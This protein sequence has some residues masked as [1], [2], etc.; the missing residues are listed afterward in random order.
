MAYLFDRDQDPLCKALGTTWYLEESDAFH[1]DILFGFRYWHSGYSHP[2]DGD[3]ITRQREEA[4]NPCQAHPG[5][6]RS[7]TA[8]FRT[9]LID[10]GRHVFFLSDPH[11]TLGW[12]L[13]CCFSKPS[14]W[15]SSL[16]ASS[17]IAPCYL[18]FYLAVHFMLS[19]FEAVQKLSFC[20]LRYLQG[21]T[22]PGSQ[23]GGP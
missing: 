14:A 11:V 6:S 17:F 2:F 10:I 20:N 15:D 22:L 16:L 7:W 13:F 3:H 4:M 19:A 8:Q 9:H 1:R 23:E 12:G 5:D 18:T 21:N